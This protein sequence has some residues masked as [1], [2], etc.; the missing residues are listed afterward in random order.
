MVYPA[1]QIR[2]A[3]IDDAQE[4]LSMFALL[5][6]ET[7]FML[8]EPGERKTTLTEQENIISN[9]SNDPSKVM[10]LAIDEQIA[11]FV[12]GIG[13]ALTRNKH[14]FYC[15]IGVLQQFTGQGVGKQL[16]NKL[17]SWA[18]E[19][20]IHRLELT[21]MEHNERAIKLY[22][23]LGFE[24]EGIKRDSLKV[25]GEFVNEIYMSKLLSS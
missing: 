11:G 22:K 13:N 2:K 9:F 15:V 25:D 17:E 1:M 16:M 23:A 20:G 19:S 21:V 18:I 3:K 14:S 8:Y 7:K 12:V 4:L 10:F 5:D 24:V 6:S